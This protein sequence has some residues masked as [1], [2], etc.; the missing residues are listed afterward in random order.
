MYTHNANIS[1]RQLRL[2][3]ILQMFNMSTLSIPRIA[4]NQAGHDGYLLPLWGF[5]IG[6]IYVYVITKVLAQFPNEGLDTFSKKALGKTLGSLVVIVYSLKIL[7]GMGLEVRFFGEMISKVLL[8]N[9]PLAVIVLF[10]LFSV[11]YLVKSGLE[12]TGRM[13]EL[14]A[15]FVFVPLIFV[16]LLVLI[17]ADYG[18]LLPLLQARIQDVGIGA[19]T[20]S[21]TFMPLEFLLMIG[22]LVNKP[23]KLK[24]A[25][26]WA[27]GVIAVLESAIIALTFIGIGMLTSSKQIWPLLT[28]MESI[29]LPGSLFEN[30]EI[31]MMSWWVMSVYMYVCGGLYVV[32]LIISK[33]FRFNR[34][35]V[36]S[37]PLLPIIYFI[38]IIPGSLGEAYT[39]LTMYHRYTGSL[40]LLVVP[41]IILIV[42]KLRKVGGSHDY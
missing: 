29:R 6:Y 2:L 4:A 20:M 23:S 10:L 17:K 32:S 42:S 13:A 1:I 41:L 5:L 8:P 35:N 24:K 26:L 30:Q 36:T 3:L 21:L 7:I 28:L 33:T 14:L 15:Y 34:Q 9:T 39:Y 37:L 27:I 22:A 40:F 11:Y 38:A 12:A 31:L 19:Y 16:L 18:E 25:C